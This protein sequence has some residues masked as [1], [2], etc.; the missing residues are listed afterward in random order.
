MT[1]PMFFSIRARAAFEP[2]EPSLATSTL[3]L[4]LLLLLP[5]PPAV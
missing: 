4:L 2:S 3:L 5:L 1:S